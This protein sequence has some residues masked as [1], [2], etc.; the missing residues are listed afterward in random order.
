[1]SFSKA[2]L[3]MHYKSLFVY[4]INQIKAIYIQFISFRS[5]D[6]FIVDVKPGFVETYLVMLA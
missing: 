2:H 1:M 3:L 4:K 6:D 5:S